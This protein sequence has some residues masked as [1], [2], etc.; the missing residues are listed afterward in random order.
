MRQTSLANISVQLATYQNNYHTI[1][2]PQ[3]YRLDLDS[4]GCG[5]GTL[6]VSLTFALMD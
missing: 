6:L 3:Q 4:G 5:L 1:I 2:E